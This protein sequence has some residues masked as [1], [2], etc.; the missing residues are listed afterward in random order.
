MKKKRD[1]DIFPR[2][3]KSRVLL[4]AAFIGGLAIIPG[5]LV[6]MGLGHEGI[7]LTIENH[8]SDEVT[9]L[10]DRRAWGSVAAEGSET[11]VTYESNW[12]DPRLIEVVDQSGKELYSASLSRDDLDRMDHRIVIEAPDDD[13]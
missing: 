9:V 13:P 11:F 6:L 12:R 2:T 7:D 5:S 4:A 10:V 8:T 3:W 1:Y